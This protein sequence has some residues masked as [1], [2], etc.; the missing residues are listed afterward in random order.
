MRG[1]TLHNFMVAR[2]KLF[3]I[4]ILW[5]VFTEFKISQNGVI[6]YAD[7][8]AIYSNLAIIFEIETTS[9]H[10]IDNC[11]KAQAV[12]I[13]L[14]IIVPDTALLKTASAKLDKLD[15]KPGGC[16][17]KLFRLNQLHNEV[18]NYLSLFI[19]ANS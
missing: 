18:T 11:L 15:I 8:L 16:R 7:I 1:E 6:N 2:T 9:R 14:C 5:K 3:L 10:I 17:I 12:N 13:P 4:G 19:A